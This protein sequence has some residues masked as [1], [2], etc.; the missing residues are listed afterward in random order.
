MVVTQAPRTWPDAIEVLAIDLNVRERSDDEA[1]HT[2]ATAARHLRAASPRVFVKI[3]STLRGPIGGL[4]AGALAGSQKAL[5]VIAPSFPEQ[6][7][8]V[9][10][11]QLVAILGAST[12]HRIIDAQDGESLHR[13]AEASREHPEWLLVGSAGLARH[14]AG[15]PHPKQIKAQ[16]D[17]PILVVAGSPSCVTREQ[18]VYL[19]GLS[20][21]TVL[22]T[23]HTELRDAGETAMALADAVAEWSM[24]NT[25]RAVVLTGGATGRAVL[26]RLG[27]SQVRIHGELEPGI[28]VGS[29]PD[30]RPV[31]TK[32]GGFG[33]P[34]TLLDVV[35][36][37][38]V[39]SRG[40]AH[41]SA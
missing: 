28:P 11:N 14:L 37:L 36:S 30:G 8:L 17:G 13:L 31:V 5:A 33:R 20:E 16:G 27:V 23:P 32:A 38:G 9:A 40:L 39:S 24:R 12:C 22:G 1:H 34:E 15:Q 4:V 21:V 6:G 35:R 25:P 10:P 26:A 2:T 41:D 29:L 7:R 18:L 3:D 19:E